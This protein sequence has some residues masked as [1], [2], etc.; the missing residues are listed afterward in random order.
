MASPVA[1]LLGIPLTVR[2]DVEQKIME[3]RPVFKQ[4][5]TTVTICEAELTSINKAVTSLQQKL[6]AS[7]AEHRQTHPGLMMSLEK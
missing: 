7:L 4:A 6:D 1:D 2:K 3:S 5:T